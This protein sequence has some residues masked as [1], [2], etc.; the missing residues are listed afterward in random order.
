MA[1]AMFSML[2]CKLLRLLWLSQQV[3]LKRNEGWKKNA[4]KTKRP[5]WYG[6]HINKNREKNIDDALPSSL[7]DSNVSMK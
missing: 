7:I 1:I 2:K 6:L 5:K 3:R 4:F